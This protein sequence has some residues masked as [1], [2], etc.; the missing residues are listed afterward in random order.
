MTLDLKKNIYYEPHIP[1]S[2]LKKI[3]L[4]HEHEFVRLIR[5]I[6]GTI[7]Y[8]IFAEEYILF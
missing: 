3:F 5:Q 2:I 1:E 7:V 8:N 4:M 6:D